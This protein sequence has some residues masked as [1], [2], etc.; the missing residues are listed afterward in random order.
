M[1]KGI[2]IA[3]SMLMLASAY[4]QTSPAITSW[5]INNTGITGRHYL[6]GNSTPIVDT[7]PANVQLVQY[8]DDYVYINSSGIPAYIIGPYPDGNPALGTDNEHLF[9]LPLAPVENTGTLTATPFGPIGVL[10]NGVP[11][12]DY[13]DGASYSLS[14]GQDEMGNPMGGGSGDGAWNRNAIMAENEGFDCAKGHP[15]PMFSGGGP[16]S[17]TLVGGTYHHHQNPTAFNLDLV[18]IS[19]ICDLYLADGLYTIDSTEHS[20]LLGFAFDG[21]PIYGAYGYDNTDGTGGIV[22]MESSYQKRNITTRTEYADGTNVTDGPAVSSTYPLGWYREDFE[23]IASSGHLD[24]HNGRF[25][26]TPEYPDGIYAY[27]ATVDENWNSAYPYMVGPEYYGVVEQSNITVGGGAG[28]TI[29]EPVTVF[30]P[31]TSTTPD[32]TVGVGA[33]PDLQEIDVTVFPNP[34][35][36]L[37]AVQV[38]GV[39]TKD[40]HVVVYNLQGQLVAEGT[41]NQGSTIWHLDTRTLYNGDYILVVGNNQVTKRFVIAR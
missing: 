24:E 34:S 15:S 16:G 40:L 11:I 22:R 25:C 36:D 12:Y 30:T 13:K 9:K 29:S 28:V 19:S 10:I 33:A 14:T 32:T 6:E 26:V 37:V 20:P 23:F 4:A 27:F 1:K 31:D 8:S 21:F 41:I 7:F 35:A 17:G 39:S 18:E 2:L 3:F 5:M 38:A